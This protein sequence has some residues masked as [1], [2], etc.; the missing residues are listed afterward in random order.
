[1]SH[2]FKVFSQVLEAVLSFYIKEFEEEC[3]IGSDVPG[4]IFEHDSII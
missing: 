3:S 1:M 4:R 2:A